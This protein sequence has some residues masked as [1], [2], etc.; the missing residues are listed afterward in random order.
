MN[1]PLSGCD[2]AYTLSG[3]LVPSGIAFC[4][5]VHRGFESKNEST[6]T[7]AGEND[8]G[9]VTLIERGKPDVTTKFTSA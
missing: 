2:A 7:R 1:D 3:P 6:E 4:V 5:T 8:S 9:A